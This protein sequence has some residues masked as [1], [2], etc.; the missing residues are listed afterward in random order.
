MTEHMRDEAP[1]SRDARTEYP[2]C[3]SARAD[4]SLLHD[5]ECDEACRTRL[6]KHLADCPSCRERFIS[7]KRIRT[8]L[9]RSCQEMAPNGLREK[10]IVQMRRTTV[11]TTDGDGN[12]VVNHTT[13][14]EE[15]R[16]E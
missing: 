3:E 8:M 10:L 12:T 13:T 6:E 2:D 7:E 11:T 1:V 9:S 15:R 5:C 14:V 4:L 16:S